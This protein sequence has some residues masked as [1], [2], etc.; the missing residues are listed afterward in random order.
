[1]KPAPFA[2]VRPASVDEALKA[3]ADHGGSARP[4]AGGQSLVP[5]LNMRLMRPAAI[6][7]INRVAGL[8]AIAAAGAGTTLGALV[9]Y[10]TIERDPMVAERLPLLQQ[11]TRW[12]GDRQVRNRGTIGGSLAQADPTGEMPLACLALDAAVVTRS[13]AGTRTIAIDDFIE[14]SYLTALEP[15]ELITEV[16]FPAGPA[17]C[18]FEEVGRR[19][20]DFAVVSVAVTGTPAPDGRWSGVRIALTGVDDR[21]VLAAAAAAALEGSALEPDAIEAAAEA[22][23]EGADPPSDV[24]ASA[25]YRSHLAV[26]LVARV[27]AR[28]RDERT[29]AH[30]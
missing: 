3:L 30:G 23:L 15:D 9:R 6:V 11:V 4:L 14:G 20:N 10:S 22:C 8:D 12:I 13:T 5:M 28:L 27:L 2:Y 16:R 7:D 19:H 17:A 21:P 29:A 25:D 18:A 1:M 24:R 26:R